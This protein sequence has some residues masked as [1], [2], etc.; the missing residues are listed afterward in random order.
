[1]RSDP[2][3]NPYDEARA[4]TYHPAWTG[5]LARTL[6]FIIRATCLDAHDEL[7]RAYRALF[8]A[9]FPPR[10]TALFDD[11]HMVDYEAALG[12]I[13]SAVSSGNPVDEAALGNRLVVA[14]RAQYRAVAALAEAGE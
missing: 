1:L 11:V 5:P 3:E 13:R 14:A 12:P 6:T 4:F 10:A 7:A 8:R 9:G 2:G